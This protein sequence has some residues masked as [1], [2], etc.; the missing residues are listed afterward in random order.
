[1]ATVCMIRMDELF[2]AAPTLQ[3]VFFVF[4]VSKVWFQ[5]YKHTDQHVPYR[6]TF[7]L[8]RMYCVVPGK[9]SGMFGV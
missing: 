3:A 4:L 6:F 1:M 2:T 5:W 9:E 7:R 8:P